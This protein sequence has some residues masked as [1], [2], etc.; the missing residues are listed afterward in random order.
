MQ[1]IVRV[2]V[3]STWL[4]LQPERAA[5][6]KALQRMRQTKLNGMEYFGS[7]D[8]NTRDTSLAEVDRSDVY[9]GIIGGRYGSGIT[10][11]EYRRAS[12]K[13]LPRFLYFKD[14]QA[15]SADGRDAEGEK[16]TRFV[17]WKE[18]LR[19]THAL[20]TGPFTSPGDLAA[21]VTA[22]LSN[23][24][25]EQCGP[26]LFL[27]GVGSLPYDYA[28]RI[29]NFLSEYLGT[30]TAPVPFGGR[31]QDLKTLDDWLEDNNSPPYLMMAAPAG[32]GKS[33]LLVRWTRR[34]LARPQ[35]SL[36]F[37]PISIRFRTNLSAVTFATLAARLATLQGE[38]V[39]ETPSTTAEVWRGLVTDYLKRP[40]PNGETLVVVLDGLDEAA[41]WEPGPDL[42][43]LTPPDHVRIVVSARYRTGDTGASD[44]LRRLGWERKGL[45]RSIDLSTLTKEGVARVLESMGFP[46]AHLGAK[47]DIMSELYRLTE[48]DPLLVKLY[49][50]DL[51]SRKETVGSLKPKDLSQLKPGL[52]GYFDRW[53]DDQRKLWGKESPLKEQAVQTLLSAL[54]CS[55]GPLD[56]DGLLQ[57]TKLSSWDLREALKPLDRFIIGDGKAHGYAFSHPRLGDYFKDALAA[58]EQ[59]TWQQRF[60]DWGK[61]TVQALEDGSLLP[62]KAPAYIVQYYGAHLEQAHAQTDTLLTL[63]CQGWSKAWEALEGSFSGF[64]TMSSVPGRLPNVRMNKPLL[65]AKSLPVSETKSA[66]H[67]PEPASIVWLTTYRSS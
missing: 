24:L 21:K 63:V 11:E 67:S 1:P 17:N 13:K 50:E 6:E 47:V 19:K 4:D 38:K 14:E 25:F 18:E 2:Y 20:G 51:W 37:V 55:L 52:N 33:A 7:R 34:L 60:L 16:Q 54:A 66:A 61:E 40:L 49:V 5:V 23:W 64:L 41:D 45:A 26:Q 8:E 29:E 44:W 12:E 9:V 32:R 48:G 15:I 46:L 58:S 27:N 43:P 3:S 59:Q 39:P 42:F 28:P 56:Q 31:E 36:V 65:K 35:I 57:L 10:E 62:A 53:W 22:D 30:S